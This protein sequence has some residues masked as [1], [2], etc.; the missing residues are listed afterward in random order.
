MMAHPQVL[1][2][3]VLEHSV[4]GKS[5][6]RAFRPMESPCG[7]GSEGV[8]RQASATRLRRVALLGAAMVCPALAAG[9]VSAAGSPA[10]QFIRHDIDSGVFG[11]VTQ[12][13]GVGDIDGDGR[14]DIVVGG[15]N[16][17]V[18]F[19]NPDWTPN[20]IASG[21]KFAGGAVVVVR[22]IDG[23]GRLDVMTGKYPLGDNS[24]RETVWFGNT[25]SGWVEHVVSTTNFC[26]D[27]AFAD[28]DGDGHEDAVCA[29]QF[30]YQV[31]WLHGPATPTDPWPST[32]IDAGPRPMGTAVADIDR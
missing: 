19:H 14:P 11:Q 23:D 12:G 18:W 13:L 30:L 20:L 25:P 6:S 3:G 5:V 9:P 8:S 28:F 16:Y 17:L 24:Q 10:L 2:R 7:Q 1:S 29:D 22:D 21:F 26:H 31:A 4:S 32:V 15:D 27:L